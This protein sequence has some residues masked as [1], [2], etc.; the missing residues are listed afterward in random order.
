MLELFNSGNS[1]LNKD[2]AGLVSSY[3]LDHNEYNALTWIVDRDYPLKSRSLQEDDEVLNPFGY[4][5]CVSS[6]TK[7]LLL[8]NGYVDS[9]NKYPFM[10]YPE[11]HQPSGSVSSYVYSWSLFPSDNQPSGSSNFSKILN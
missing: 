3:L 4:F 7:E 9:Y 6:R 1:L 2:I 10:L 8:K 11:D 5:A